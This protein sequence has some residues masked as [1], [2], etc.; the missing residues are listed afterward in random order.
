ME[1]TNDSLISDGRDVHG[2]EKFRVF[3]LPHKDM[4]MRITYST[5]RGKEHNLFQKTELKSGKIL[6]LPAAAEPFGFGLTTGQHNIIFDVDGKKELI[7][8]VNVK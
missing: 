2:G 8:K 1:E 6:K 7:L 4:Q 3:I 5:E